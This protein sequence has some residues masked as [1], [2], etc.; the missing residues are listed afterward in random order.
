MVVPVALPLKRPFRPDLG[1]EVTG[2]IEDFCIAHHEANA[3]E[4]VR[5]A[6]KAFIPRDLHLN[7]G[8]RLVYEALQA[9]R[10]RASSASSPSTGAKSDEP[11]PRE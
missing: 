3:T 2:M 1:E 4:T 5:K 10:K 7:E 11:P 6:V 8:A 9:A